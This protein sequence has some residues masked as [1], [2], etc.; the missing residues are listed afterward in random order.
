MCRRVD[1]SHHKPN[2]HQTSHIFCPFVIHSP[3]YSL[4]LL[5]SNVGLH[6]EEAIRIVPE[7]HN[8]ISQSHSTFSP[9][10][11]ENR[12]MKSKDQNQRY[13][14]IL[15]VIIELVRWVFFFFLKEVRWVRI[16]WYEI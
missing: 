11:I 2:S 14:F 8:Q 12:E 13:L 10:L 6:D 5:R 16:S 9:Y 15:S 7:Q 1:M 4:V 3:Y